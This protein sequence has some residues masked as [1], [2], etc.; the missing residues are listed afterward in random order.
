MLVAA[1]TL[2]DAVAL[3]VAIPDCNKCTLPSADSV[4]ELDLSVPV[5][6]DDPATAIWGVTRAVAAPT[7][8]LHAGAAAPAA[9][10]ATRNKRLRNRGSRWK[11]KMRA[12]LFAGDATVECVWCRHPM[13]PH[14]ATLEHIQPLSA[15]GTNAPENLDLSCWDCNSR[16]GTAAWV[17]VRERRR[18]APIAPPEWRAFKAPAAGGVLAEAA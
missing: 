8:D 7:A 4:R 17:P 1:P 15:G 11:I 16:R 5:F 13:Q 2:E 14:E 3:F 12:R 10:P 18:P 9:P 6:A